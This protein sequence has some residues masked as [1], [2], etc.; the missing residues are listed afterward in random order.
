[1]VHTCSQYICIEVEAGCW[2]D[3][4][5]SNAGVANNFFLLASNELHTQYIQ[6]QRLGGTRL[7]VDGLHLPFVSFVIWMVQQD[8]G[9]I[10]GRVMVYP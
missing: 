9:S 5:S 7:V 8:T 4:G 2:F 1:M 6:L 3:S 10:P